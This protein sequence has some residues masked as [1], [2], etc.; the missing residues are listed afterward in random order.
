[1]GRVGEDSQK[2]KLEKRREEK[3]INEEKVRERQKKEDAAARKGTKVVKHYL[4]Q[5]S[6]SCGSGGSTNRLTKAAGIEPAGQIR[7]EQ[8]HAVCGA[9]HI[10]TSQHV[11]STP[12]PDHFWT[13]DVE[14]RKKCTPVWREAVK[15]HK[16][17]QAR[18][19]FGN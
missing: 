10:S 13:L 11:Q 6:C 7:H 1:M 5:M 4:C 18:T 3:H 16:T 9:K 8:L 2:R 14:M 17:H 12:G 19:T 15:M